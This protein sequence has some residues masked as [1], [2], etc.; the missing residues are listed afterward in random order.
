MKKNPLKFPISLKILL[1]FIPLLAL[2]FC[3]AALTLVRLDKVNRINRELVSIDMVAEKSALTMR[4]ILLAQ[5]SYGRRYMVLKS[6]EMLSIFRQRENEFAMECSLAKKMAPWYPALDSVKQSHD[7][8]LRLSGL[9][10]GI[11]DSSPTASSATDSLLRNAFNRQENLLRTIST[12]ARR[13]QS[14]KMAMIAAVG[15]ATYRQVAILAGAGIA[16]ILLFTLLISGNILHSISTLKTAA[17]MVAC[18]TFIHL[19]RVK[20]RDELGELSTAFN[21]MADRLIKLEESNMDA[22]PL[23]RLPGGMAIENTVKQLIDRNEPFA[24]CMFDLDNFKPFNDRYGY[25]RGNSVIKMTAEIILK[26]ARESGDGAGFVGHIGGD[27]FVLIG[28]TEQFEEQCGRIIE[29]FDRRIIEHYDEEDRAQKG[30]LSVSRLGE[31]RMFPIMTISI[32]AINSNK[33]VVHNYIEVGEIVAELKKFAKK[34]S[35]SNLV[36]DRR[37][38]KKR[39]SDAQKE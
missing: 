28:S 13:N 5:E 9:N 16:L 30:I 11:P 14:E 24:F 2:T 22:S 10:F 17:S 36:I 21:E 23:T 3:I 20:S 26:A 7:E 37:G 39:D 1:G 4:E 31:Q 19:P 27:D 25:A 38:G 33:T 18:G 34:F 6:D 8:Y 35:K 32:A 29:E 12:G 15:S